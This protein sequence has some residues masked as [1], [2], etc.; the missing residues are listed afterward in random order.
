VLDVGCGNGPYEALLSARGHRGAVVALDLSPGMLAEV[1]VATRVL[2]DAEHLPV[3][4]AAFDVVLAPHM[5]YHVD[6]IGRA[7]VEAR[8]ALRSG[9]RFV[10]VTN[11][12]GNIRPYTEL[13][14]RAVGTGWR[15]DRPSSER[16]SLVNGA[17]RLAPAFDS[18]TRIVAPSGD[19]VITDLDALTDY[20]ASVGDAY[21]DACGR[22]WDAVVARARE[23]AAAELERA[24]ALCWPTEVGAFVCT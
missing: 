1:P 9:G 22:P 10:A 20:I 21:A 16:F 18:V 19:V 14:E 17:A 12:P 23:L 4:R 6:D 11:G 5:L 15:M 2:A 7:A 3:A 24:G 13:V 8:R